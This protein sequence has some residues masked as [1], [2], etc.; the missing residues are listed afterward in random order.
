MCT[1]ICAYYTITFQATNALFTT[2]SHRVQLSVQ[3]LGA[4]NVKFWTI[5]VEDTNQRSTLSLE[6]HFSKV[7]RYKSCVNRIM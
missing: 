1:N 7:G 3:K 4:L 2:K 5:P 6:H